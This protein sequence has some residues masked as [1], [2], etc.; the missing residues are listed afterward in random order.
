MGV[1][2]Q[3]AL[4]L[5]QQAATAETTARNIAVVA[6]HEVERERA[7]SAA[8]RAQ[9]AAFATEAQQAISAAAA[10]ASEAQRRGQLATDAA[11]NISRKTGQAVQATITEGP[12]DVV[13]A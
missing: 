6:A 3:V 8:T 13:A 5:Q 7:S 1:D 12:A 9:A 2:P 10:E 4:Q 11:Q